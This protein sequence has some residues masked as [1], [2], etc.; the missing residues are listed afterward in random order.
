MRI[1]TP[2]QIY[3]HHYDRDPHYVELPHGE[4]TTIWDPA[5]GLRIHLTSLMVSVAGAGVL[6]LQHGDTVFATMHFNEK[7]SV[8]VNAGGDITF[9]EDAVLKATF[10]ADAGDVSGY[11]TA[12]GH[13]DP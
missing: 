12:F 9:P 11:V 4:L 7:K 2:G 1:T 13:E 6:V 3:L 5:A 10:T 8:P